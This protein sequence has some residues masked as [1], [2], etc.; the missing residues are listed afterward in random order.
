MATIEGEYD[1]KERCCGYCY[2]PSPQ[3]KCAKCPR[4][5]CSRECQVQ[6]WKKGGHKIWCGKSGE[7]CIDY[8]I[9]EA[10][11]KGLG[12][13]ALRNFNGGEKILVERSVMSRL[14]MRGTTTSSDPNVRKAIMALAPANSNSVDAKF[15]ANSVSL[16]G[17]EEGD[18]GSA[19]FIH[20]SRANHDCVGNAN[21]YYDHGIGLRLLVANRDITAGTEI[22]FSYAGTSSCD[23]RAMLIASRGFTCRCSACQ[24]PEVGAKLDKLIELDRAIVILGSNGNVEAAIRAGTRLIKIYDDLELSDILYSRTY[25]DLFQVSITKSSTVKKGHAFIKKAY[26]HALKFYGRDEN[27]TVVNYKQYVEDP[28][29][30]RNYRL[31]D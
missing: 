21:H 5:Y 4:P 6:D 16:G 31:I 17:S 30:H 3:S 12:L 18:K 20:Y 10:G 13:F 8:E 28:S 1:P 25:Y 24:V 9:R 7:K 2:A 23:E 29:A 26:T 22:T 27:E 19:L 15:M 14:P 11:D